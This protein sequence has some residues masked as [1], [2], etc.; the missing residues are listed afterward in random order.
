MLLTRRVQATANL[1]VRIEMKS[2]T[3]ANVNAINDVGG[4]LVSQAAPLHARY[5]YAYVSVSAL[6]SALAAPACV[7]VLLRASGHE[8]LFSRYA[9]IVADREKMRSDWIRKTLMQG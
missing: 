4:C 1:N 6:A 3:V 5:L 2:L 9:V 8:Q 7:G